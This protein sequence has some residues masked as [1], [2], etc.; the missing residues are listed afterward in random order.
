MTWTKEEYSDAQKA[1][2]QTHSYEAYLV[3]KDIHL[4]LESMGKDSDT[5]GDSIAHSL[6]V[7]NNSLQ[8]LTSAVRNLE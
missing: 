5:H 6:H 3:L 4:I 1:S 7:I 2:W 8:A